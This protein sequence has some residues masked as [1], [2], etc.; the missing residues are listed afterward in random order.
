METVD[1]PGTI[2]IG[3]KDRG[4]RIVVGEAGGVAIQCTLV[5]PI[6]GFFWV[7]RCKQVIGLP[8]EQ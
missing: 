7:N 1:Y 3:K 4:D 2:G 6:W 5:I 8:R